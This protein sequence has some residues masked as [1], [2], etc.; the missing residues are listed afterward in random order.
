MLVERCGEPDRGIAVA[1][2]H[3]MGV[4]VFRSPPFPSKV[5]V[6]TDATSHRDTPCT[7]NYGG[8][9]DFVTE[10]CIVWATK[11]C[12]LT[13]C[14]GADDEIRTRDPHLGKLT[15]VRASTWV[16]IRKSPLTCGFS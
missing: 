10:K 7:S 9:A 5:G 8:Q 12:P 1:A 6:D 2:G 3:G 16:D 14:S 4:E 15:K 11:M 13:C